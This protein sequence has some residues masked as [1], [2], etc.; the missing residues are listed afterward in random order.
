MADPPTIAPPPAT[1][2]DPRVSGKLGSILDIKNPWRNSFVPAS[3][4]NAQF[5]C[6]TNAREGGRRNVEHEFPKRDMPYGEDMGRKAVEFS[7]R[8]YCISYPVTNTILQNR[9]YRLAR[10][11]LLAV[12]E[13]NAPG[14]LI[15]PFAKTAMWVICSRYRLTEEDR[16]GGYC[17]FDMSFAEKGLPPVQVDQNTLAQVLINAQIALDSAANKLNGFGEPGAWNPSNQD[18]QDIVGGIGSGQ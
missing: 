6:Q 7:V 8:G 17:T 18:M 14:L 11:A 9:D 4:R 12:L 16:L 3:F 1:G 5:Y 10:D 2:P 13:D 15:L